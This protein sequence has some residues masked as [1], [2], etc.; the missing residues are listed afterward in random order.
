VIVFG[1]KTQI[2][3][4]H[5]YN[6]SKVQEKKFP[7]ECTPADLFLKVREQ[8]SYAFLL[9][10]MEGPR[11]EASFSYVG[12][13]PSL[14]F[15]AKDGLVVLQDQESGD[16]IKQRVQDPFD[17]LKELLG[18]GHPSKGTERYQ[19]GAVGYISYDAIRYFEELP[20]MTT[21]D[22]KFPDLEMGIYQDGVI[23]D[24][25]R[26]SISYFYRTD[27]RLNDVLAL[28]SQ[29]SE[30]QD[31]SYSPPTTNISQGKYESLVEQI[32]EYVTSGDIFQ[33]V[34]AR[35]YEFKI[36]GDLGRF[37]LAL[38]R[39]NPSPYMYYL[40][41][42]ERQIVGSSPEMLA[43]VSGPTIETYPIAGTRPHVDDAVKNRAMAKELLED[44]K[45]CAEHVMLVDLARNDVG[46]TA[47]FGSVSVPI[48]QEVHQY[49][50]V[51]HIVSKVIGKLRAGSDSFDALRAIFPAGTVSGAPKVRAM[52]IIEECEPTRRGPYAGAVGYF[53]FNGNMDFAITIRTLV[54]NRDR[55]VIQAGGGI[56]ADSVPET[57]W[58]ETQ[59]KAKALMRA[60]EL[61]E[62]DP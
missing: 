4:I 32:K 60:L 35:K 37:Y 47:S 42:D 51:Q 48:F 25:T 9:E 5:R 15:S 12:F 55:G 33:A 53:T 41:M 22:S 59:H 19:G 16:L 24:H 6:F 46:R 2:D 44:P 21:D 39:I 14:V 40:K 45:E 43:R 56:V 18:P 29:E 38:R 57:E 52:E 3:Q 34:L 26:G 30:I 10:S 62:V 23:F 7:V 17:L 36:K 1:L 28:T 27:N 31:L 20:Q 61:S 58:L 8:Y 50:H 11:K 49:S 13:N 54:A